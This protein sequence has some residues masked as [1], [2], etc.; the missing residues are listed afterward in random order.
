MKLKQCIY[1]QKFFSQDLKN[2]GCPK[3]EKELRDLENEKD[4]NQTTKEN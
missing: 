3:C 2:K 1:C 4:K